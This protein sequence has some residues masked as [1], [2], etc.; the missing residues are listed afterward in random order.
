MGVASL[1][2]TRTLTLRRDGGGE[3]YP[4]QLAQRYDV[5]LGLG[6]YPNPD[7]DP[8][9]LPLPL[10]PPLTPTPYPYPYPYT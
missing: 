5:C 3:V 9:P 2:L 8:L 10:P 7:P 6:L 4:Y 1:T